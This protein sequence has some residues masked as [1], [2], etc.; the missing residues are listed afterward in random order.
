MVVC[1]MNADN[2]LRKVYL[3][4]KSIRPEYYVGYYVYALAISMLFSG[5]DST[6][7]VKFYHIALAITFA[8]IYAMMWNILGDSLWRLLRTFT[9]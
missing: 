3:L 7:W 8:G 2:R 1:G 5:A 6:F 4:T 9:V